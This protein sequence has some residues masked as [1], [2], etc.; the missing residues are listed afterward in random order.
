MRSDW[1]RRR[2]HM[3]RRRGRRKVQSSREGR[4]SC[5]NRTRRRRD[6]YD[7]IIFRQTDS[8]TRSLWALHGVLSFNENDLKRLV[9]LMRWPMIDPIGLRVLP[10][11]NQNALLRASVDFGTVL[12]KHQYECLAPDLPEMRNIRF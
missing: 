10:I 8:Y 2:R 9:D 5:G 11:P 4:S 1:D 7:F 6:R 3:G 12:L